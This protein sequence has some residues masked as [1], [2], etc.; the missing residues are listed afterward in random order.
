MKDEE[1]RKEVNLM[2]E[3]LKKDKDEHRNKIKFE[4]IN[5]RLKIGAY[6]EEALNVMKEHKQKIVEEK[7]KNMELNI[8]KFMNRKMER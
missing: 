1:K 3:R 6:S 4:Q 5:R 7:R 8:Y 2:L